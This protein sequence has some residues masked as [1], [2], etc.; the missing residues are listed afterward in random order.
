MLIEKK[1]ALYEIP[2][3]KQNLNEALDKAEADWGRDLRPLLPQ[4]V[5]WEDA[6]SQIESFLRMLIA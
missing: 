2:L 4:L 5:S 6:E 1:L 3:T